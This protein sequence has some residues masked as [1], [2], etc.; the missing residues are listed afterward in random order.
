MRNRLPT[1]LAA[2]LVVVFACVPGPAAGRVAAA[3]L[4]VA[5]GG[6]DGDSCSQ[7]AP[8]ETIG[9]AVDVARTGDTIRIGK[10]VFAGT[11][12]IVLS[13]SLTLEGAGRLA[14]DVEPAFNPSSAVTIE[15]GA[16][17]HI[18]NL[19]VLRAQ[20]GSTD[21][22]VDNKGSLNLTN[23]R[24]A[25]SSGEA[26]V[27]SQGYLFL[28][29]AEIADNQT[30]GLVNSGPLAIVTRSTI[31]FNSVGVTN[32]DGALTMV[33][34]LVADNRYSGP[35]GDYTGGGGIESSGT[36]TLTNVTITGNAGGVGGLA[37]QG[38]AATL[39]NVTIARNSTLP[40]SSTSAPGGLE[41]DIGTERPV[42]ANAGTV[43][44]WNTIVADNSTPQ[45]S[46]NHGSNAGEILIGTDAGDLFGDS[47][48]VDTFPS[49]GSVWPVIGDPKLGPLRANGGPTA[50]LA[51]LA[52]S[53]AIDAGS[54]AHCPKIDQRGIPRPQDGNGDGKAV[55]DVGAYEYQP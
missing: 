14:T 34:S 24:V 40:G 12:D 3:T 38:G 33:D 4:Y 10:G 17:V 16:V 20:P 26:A 48:C 25:L 27:C 18:D 6:S 31:E 19:S 15:R 42:K 23:V 52:G 5:R 11:N 47:G 9:R 28:N 13:K 55:C 39:V 21:C 51:L 29:H 7:T 45:C 37:N 32:Y 53:P 43:R 35:P 50:T 41:T 36:L 44:L 49:S 30:T 8:C 1:A 54:S 2:A 22:A 46:T